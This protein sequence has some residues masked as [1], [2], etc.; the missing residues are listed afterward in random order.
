MR[1]LSRKTTLVALAAVVLL[2]G[3]G[4]A[5]AYWTTTGAGTGTAAAGTNVTIT[6][7]QTGVLTAL[8]PG[9]TPQTLSGTFDNNNTSPAYVATVTASI[10]SVTKAAGAPTGTC[11]ATD[12][13]LAGP[14]M[15]VGVEVPAGTAQGAWT[16]ATIAFNDKAANQDGCKLATVNI[17]YVVG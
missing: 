5:Y 13:T 15:T 3:A 8:Y 7:N 10:A 16:G 6:A 1:R 14:V 12:F 4:T 2:A 17:A 11:E 9:A